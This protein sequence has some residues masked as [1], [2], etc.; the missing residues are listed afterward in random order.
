MDPGTFQIIWFVVMAT[1]LSIFW[2]QGGIALKIYPTLE[3]VNIRFREKWASGYSNDSF[4]TR[5]GGAQ[6]ILDIIVTTEELWVRTP[7]L[8]AG[9]SAQFGT[10]KKLELTQVKA[11]EINNSSVRIEIAEKFNKTSEIILKMKRPDEF[12]STIENLQ[13]GNKKSI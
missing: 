2:I 8:F 11:I 1:I 10:L 4:K 13:T 7:R 9:M 3:S 6:N 12:K 5:M